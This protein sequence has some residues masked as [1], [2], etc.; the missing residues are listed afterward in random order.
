LDILKL[1]IQTENYKP[2]KDET[3]LNRADLISGKI[4]DLK[5]IE[6]KANIGEVRFKQSHR[7]KKKDLES[8]V[9]NAKYVNEY[10]NFILAMVLDPFEYM[11]RRLLN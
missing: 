7:V 6:E 10:E 4:S 8:E 9:K 2:N 3:D 5:Q 11:V 1:N